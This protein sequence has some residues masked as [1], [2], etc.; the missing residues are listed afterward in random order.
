MMVCG[1]VCGCDLDWNILAVSA[2]RRRGQS[3]MA[4]SR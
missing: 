2:V 3:A 1:I 4:R